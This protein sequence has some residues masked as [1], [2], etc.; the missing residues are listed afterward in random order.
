MKA[1][2]VEIGGSLYDEEHL[3]TAKKI[4]D[5]YKHK[6]IPL[7]LPVDFICADSPEAAS[8]AAFETIPSTKLGLDIGPKTIELFKRELSKAKTILW[9][10]P[11]GVF[12]N[13]AFAKGTY[14]IASFLSAVSATTI[15]G[16]GD[17]VAAINETGLSDKFTHLSTGGGASLEFIELGT[18]PGIEAL[19]RR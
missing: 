6:N 10:G 5:T 11:M 1:K 18:L 19:T 17:S 7:H 8:G 14:E 2:G 15:V 9:N 13:P 16:G 4:M 3:E 12:E